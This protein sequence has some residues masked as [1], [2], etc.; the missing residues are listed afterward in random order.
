M[1][2]IIFVSI[3][4]AIFVSCDQFT[5]S[6][7]EKLANRSIKKI[8]PSKTIG[9]DCSDLFKFKNELVSAKFYNLGRVTHNL[10]SFQ[11]INAKNC[12]TLRYQD[13]LDVKVV[14]YL[15]KN[16]KVKCDSD[17]FDKVVRIKCPK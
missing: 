5:D 6:M 11:I 1:L 14:A 2:K 17:N 3:S 13:K 15:K 16:K 8:K 4:L 7:D 12:P 10:N 9:I